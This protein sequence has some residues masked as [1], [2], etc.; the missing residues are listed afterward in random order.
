MPQTPEPFPWREVMT[1]G[2]GILKLSPTQFW[3]ATPREI[4][5]AMQAYQNATPRPPSQQDLVELLRQ[6][7]D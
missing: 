2:L 3:N 1:F 6:F 4:F 5:A 7:P